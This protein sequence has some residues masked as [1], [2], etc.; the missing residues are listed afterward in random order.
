M[1]KVGLTGGIACGKSLALKYFSELGVPTLSADQIARELLS[2]QH[3]ERLETVRNYFG[4]AVFCSAQQLDRAALRDIIF[5]N[6]EARKWLEAQLHPAIRDA[7]QQFFRQQ[8]S[9][10]ALAEVPLLFESGMNQDMDCTVTVDC[11]KAQQKA[12]L[13]QRD[14]SSPTQIDAMLESQW[15]LQRKR[16]AA[17]FVLTNRGNQES[18]KNQVLK[19]HNSWMKAA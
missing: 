2:E 10:Y 12:R 6:P 9:P 4:D 14:G 1:R 17:D 8:H 7:L 13:Q 18:L 5:T 19:L 15:P 11:S 3:P 16:L